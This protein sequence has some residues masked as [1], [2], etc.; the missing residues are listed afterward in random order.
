[1]TGTRV[2]PFAALLQVL[3]SR[4]KQFGPDR[5]ALHGQYDNVDGVPS[6]TLDDGRVIPHPVTT[7]GVTLGHRVIAIWMQGG[8]DVCLLPLVAS[9]I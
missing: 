1:M 2:D 5:T 4:S 3:D 9:S 7:A 8:H 6:V